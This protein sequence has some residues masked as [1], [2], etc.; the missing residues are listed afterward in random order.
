MAP[1]PPR[2]RWRRRLQ[3]NVPPFIELTG[4]TAAVQ[5]RR[6]GGPGRGLPDSIDYKDGSLV[7]KGDPLFQIEPTTY[8]A[9]VKQAEAEL[10]LGQGA[11]GPGPGRV[12]S[13]RRRC[14]ARTCRRRTPT[15]RP[16]P[17]AIRRGQRREQRGQPRHR[18][19]QS[20]LHQGRRAVR[21][22]R[23]RHLVSV[24]ELV[25]ASTA[26]QARD[27]HPAR[28]DLRHLQHERAAGAAT[29]APSSRRGRC[30]LEDISKIPIEIGL[31]TEEGYPAQG[32]PRLRLALGSTP[33]TGTMLVRGMFD[34]PDAR[35]AA[36][37]LRARARCR[38][39]LG[40]QDGAARA[41]PGR[42]RG[43]G[44]QIPAGGQQGRRGRAAPR[45]HRHAAARRPAGDRQAA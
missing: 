19:D 42:R 20:R 43:P 34:N 39:G 12:R 36:R 11:A 27:H 5:H 45:H 3:Q 38:L 41:R 35:P 13:A 44:R 26:D 16:R 32:P 23:H 22:H 1:P 18:P 40:R 33:T 8:E 7:K 37:L 4:N 14:C 6:P 28:P 31:M 15:T 29:S 24:G 17:S 30:R 9:K 25:G 10:D 2:S 21:R